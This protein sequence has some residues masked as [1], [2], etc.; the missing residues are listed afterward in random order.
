MKYLLNS[1]TAAG[2]IPDIFQTWHEILEWGE[3][4]RPRDENFL[5]DRIFIPQPAAPG[6][7]TTLFHNRSPQG[8]RQDF[9]FAAGRYRSEDVCIPQPVAPGATTRFPFRGQPPQERRQDFHFTAGRPRSDDNIV[10]R[11]PACGKPPQE[12]RQYCNSAAGPVL[13]TSEIQLDPATFLYFH[14]KPS[15]FLMIPHFS[16]WPRIRPL[17]DLF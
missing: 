2:H 9:Y 7:T 17:L 1:R 15:D 5:P 13:H 14:W 6:T 3:A 12:R 11:Q 8:R 10:I 4:A 16:F